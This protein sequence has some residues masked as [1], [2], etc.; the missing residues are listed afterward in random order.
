M[1]LLYNLG[2]FFYGSFDSLTS[3]RKQDLQLINE[4]EAVSSL[5]PILRPIYSY[6]FKGCSYAW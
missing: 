6:L 3:W 2:K 4:D 1:Y 5:H